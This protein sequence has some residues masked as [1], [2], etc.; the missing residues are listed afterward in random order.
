VVPAPGINPNKSVS[1]TKNKSESEDLRTADK[2]R[3]V[4]DVRSDGYDVVAF[5]SRA[6]LLRGTPFLVP[7]WAKGEVQLGGNSKPTSGVLKF[8]VSNHQVMALRPQGDSI[9]LE[10]GKIKT[11]TLRTVGDDGKPTE[12]RFVQIPGGM[13]PGATYSF[14]EEISAGN[15]VTLLMLQWK[16]FIKGQFE[17]SYNSNKPV[18]SYQSNHQFYLQWADGTAEPVKPTLKNVL[19][20]LA[21]WPK[22]TGPAEADSKSKARADAE[23]AEALVQRMKLETNN[24]QK[25]ASR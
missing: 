17:T 7:G 3:N 19:T 21:D 1:S 20:V 5:D 2:I 4:T 24:R 13:V 25:L 23:L 18:D 16:T 10:A 9:I 11:F 6:R 22:A 15:G 8:D 12:R 14:A